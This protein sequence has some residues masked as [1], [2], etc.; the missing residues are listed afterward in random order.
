MITQIEESYQGV[1]CIGVSLTHDNSAL[2][3]KQGLKTT[4]RLTGDASC[5]MK[6][7]S[8][9]NEED[10]GTYIDLE[11]Q[12]VESIGALKVLYDSIGTLLKAVD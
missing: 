8:G 7:L 9:I 11:L 3:S 1:G 4:L 2:S 5:Y 12:G 10:G 6:A